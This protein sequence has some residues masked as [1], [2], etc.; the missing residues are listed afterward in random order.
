M[1]TYIKYV[2]LAAGLLFAV[3]CEHRPLVDL[4]NGHYVRVYL[5]EQI[6]NVTYGFYGETLPLPK[7]KQPIVL[8]AMLCDP[9]TG[10]VVAER[11][12]RNHGSDERGSYID[13]HIVAPKGVYNLML[14]SFGSAVTQLR[15]ENNFYKI[16]AYTR[17]VSEAYLQYIPSSRQDLD[18]STIV[19]TPEHIFHDVVENIKIGNSAEIDTLRN[20]AGDYFTAHSVVKSYY[21][22]IKVKGLKWVSSAVATLGGMAGST[23]L[24]GHGMI[25]YAEPVNLFISMDYKG[26]RR[27]SEE[28]TTLYATF[29][30]FGKLPDHQ[31]V[32]T[33]NF[34]FSRAD[35]TSQVESIDITSLFDT[36]IVRDKQWIILDHEIVITPPEGGS[37]GGMTPG[38]DEWKNVEEDLQM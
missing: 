2:I 5:D 31:S 24:H 34:E 27:S 14:V 25:D 37:A 19:N 26:E 6:K 15:G 7:Y 23:L 21:I 10:D 12:L 11:Y 16:E 9:L 35:G 38:V 30:T 3:S 36:E 28:L 4:N 13:G 33:L 18:E 20:D 22:Q 17:P 1:I 29:N 8:R 32:Y